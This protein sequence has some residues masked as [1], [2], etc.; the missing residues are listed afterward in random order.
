M[1]KKEIS[2][3][4]L[5]DNYPKQMTRCIPSGSGA[6]CPTAITLD[7]QVQCSLGC[8]PDTTM[9]LYRFRAQHGKTLR[10]GAPDSM[11]L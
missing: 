6:W 8:L 7:N 5:T 1:G 2:K 3:I 4:K 11:Y 9:K 10:P